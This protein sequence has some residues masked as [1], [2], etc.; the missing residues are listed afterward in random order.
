MATISSGAG[1]RWKP[2]TIACTFSTPLAFWTCRTELITPAWP[3]DV[4]TTSP[5]SFT[6]Y[7][8]ACSP[9]KLSLTR[10][11]GFASILT[12]PK[13]VAEQAESHRPGLEPRRGRRALEV[14]QPRNLARRER[15]GRPTTGGCWRARHLEPAALQRDAVELPLVDGGGRRDHHAVAE[16]VLAA[17]V[18][19]D[20]RLRAVPCSALSAGRAP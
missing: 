1:A 3:Q 13:C 14:G 10:S 11:P 4:M 7:A 6:R 8:V 20:A 16:R 18:E 17:R 5:R 15:R 19:R 12:S 9:W 2:P